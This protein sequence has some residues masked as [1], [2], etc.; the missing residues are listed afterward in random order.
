[1]L[2][3]IRAFLRRIG[4]NALVIAH[5]DEYQNETLS[6]D[7]ERLA[8]V[9]GF[10]GSAGLAIITPRQAVLF[11]DGRYVEQAKKQT[12]FKVYH[13]PRQ[14]TVNEWFTQFLR[15]SYIVAYDP[16]CHTVR[17]VN[18]WSEIFTKRGA[19]LLPYTPNPIDK[20]WLTR[21]AAKP[22]HVFDYPKQ[23]AGKTTKQKIF[24][25]KKILK[26]NG[27]D[28]FVVTSPDTV[29][30]ILNKRSDAVAY[31]P[32]YLGRLIIWASGE[33]M[34]WTEENIALLKGK[35]IGV[36]PNECPVKI[37]Q[38]ATNAGAS[39][40][41]MTNPFLR[42]KAV[43]NKVEIQGM[44]EAAF[45][46]SIAL[47]RF[48]ARIAKSPQKG[49]ELSVLPQLE[50]FRRQ[51]VLYRE[52]SFE[53]IS[54]VGRNAALPHYEPIEGKESLLKGAMLYL[55]DSGAHYWCGTTDVT[56][57]VA[58]SKPSPLMKKRYTQVLKGHIN[59][60]KA[61]FPEGTNG[62]NLDVLA[63]QPL[64]EEG[65]DFDHG[66]GHG[67]GCFLNV[68]EM[69]PTISRYAT[70]PLL[71]GMIVSNEPG[72]YARGKFGIRIENMMMVVKEKKAHKGFLT[73]E[74]L[75]YLPFCDELMD[76]TML[77]DEEKQWISDYYTEMVYRIYPKLDDETQKWM[78]KQVRRWIRREKK[79]S[80]SS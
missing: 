10:T 1:M 48:F 45:L 53:P 40:H 36:D 19:Q 49:T 63:R 65:L 41:L 64:W 23:L 50:M 30:W 66:T 6:P 44:Q 13:V 14:R 56:R 71:P 12:K 33:V 37:K 57:T 55:L 61:V 46:D 54:A 68:H 3:E 24:P 35:I 21:P 43:K 25:V 17:Q 79:S 42:L 34:P 28:A 4:A 60:A 27:L 67:I 69:P 9:T 15:P 80:I 5:D 39:I 22:V 72:F 59:L 18:A 74:M 70:E 73:F 75:T 58:L 51:S 32:L 47:C 62:A 78:K 7:K 38:D 16:W 76:E 11:V 2:K 52:N 20:F 29:S 8:Y 26:Q 31:A 77:S